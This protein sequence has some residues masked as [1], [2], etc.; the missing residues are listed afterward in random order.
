[1]TR[2]RPLLIALVL[3]VTLN[4]FLLG[5]GVARWMHA[6]GHDGRGGPFAGH[7]M[8]HGP[9]AGAARLLFRSTLEK[10]REALREQRQRLREAQRA[11]RDALAAEPFDRPAL[12]LALQQLRQA[13]S[14]S[15]HLMHDALAEIAPTL[16]REQRAQLARNARMLGGFFNHD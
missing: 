14:D 11:V 15:Q 3:S 4:L 1:M 13:T 2:S 7:G 5:F 16:T 6:A 8:P 9:M 12:D 10:R